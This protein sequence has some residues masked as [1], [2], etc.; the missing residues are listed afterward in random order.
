MY[1][2]FNCLQA[3]FF[4]CVKNWG[5]C[6]VLP[7]TSFLFVIPPKWEQISEAKGSLGIWICLHSFPQVPSKVWQ[8]WNF[9]IFLNLNMLAMHNLYPSLSEESNFPDCPDASFYKTWV[10]FSLNVKTSEA[11]WKPN[12]TF[13]SWTQWPYFIS[14]TH[15][16]S[17]ESWDCHS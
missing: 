6:L 1:V 10:Q 13:L 2:Y 4:Y 14:L 12:A 11:H 8:A 17:D 15:M 3:L 7:N 9:V 5:S 16:C